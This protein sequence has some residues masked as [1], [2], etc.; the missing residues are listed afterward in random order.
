MESPCKKTTKVVNEQRPE[1]LEATSPVVSEV[2][3]SRQKF[4]RRKDNECRVEWITASTRKMK[5]LYNCDVIMYQLNVK[6]KAA[7]PNEVTT[8]QIA[9][10]SRC[11]RGVIM[12]D[13]NYHLTCSS[14]RQ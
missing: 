13:K 3:S 2:P 14:E 9:E 11:R 7:H 1:H 12:T 8:R 5:K 4:V 6:S 10:R